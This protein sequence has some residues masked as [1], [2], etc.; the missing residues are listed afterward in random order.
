MLPAAKPQR[1]LLV[2][3]ALVALAMA[4]GWRSFQAVPLETVSE[5]TANVSIGDLNG[6]GHL[7]LGLA[8]GRYWP[9]PGCISTTARAATT[10]A[11][12]S[13]MPRALS[14]GLLPPIWMAMAIRTW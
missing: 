13:A 1:L 8:K 9:L 3:A 10:P 11:F 12:R 5:T 14:M 6:D 4:A 7:D 2:I